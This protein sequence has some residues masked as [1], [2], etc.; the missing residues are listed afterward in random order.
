MSE[1]KRTAERAYFEGFRRTHCEPEG[2]VT[3][4]DRPDV[5]VRG[6]RTIG[7]EITRLYL[8]PGSDPASEQRQRPLRDAVVS[9]A[10]RLFTARGGP[11]IEWTIGF[12]AGSLAAGRTKKVAEALAD[13]A[14]HYERDIAAGVEEDISQE[15]WRE[16]YETALPEVSFLWVSRAKPAEP[17]WRVMQ[18]YG[19]DLMSP[20]AV[21]A[22]VDQKEVEAEGYAACDALWLLIVVEAMDAAQDQEIRLDSLAV[23]S[24]VYERVIVY[25]TFGHVVEAQL[26]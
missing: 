11:P 16:L 23:R 15:V 21:Q 12:R 4:G 26:G 8:R 24:S 14:L 18:N 9:Q 7:V 22:V 1:R 19:V 13:F 6:K 2:D 3:F 10:H 25:S 20:E 17:L 5:T